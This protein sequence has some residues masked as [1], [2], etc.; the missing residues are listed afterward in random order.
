MERRRFLQVTGGGAL[1]LLGGAG[2]L[3]TRETRGVP[4]PAEPLRFFTPRE[5]AIFTAVAETV[6]QPPA[7]QPTVKEIGVALRADA[8]LASKDA[9]SRKDVRRLLALFDNALAGFMLNGSVAPFSQL[10]LVGREEFLRTWQDHR[11]PVLRAGFSVLKRL[12]AT[13]YYS[14]PSTHR[15]IGYPGPPELLP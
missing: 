15:G 7:G 4:L 10:D 5:Y 14:H 2:L 3:F 9:D 6:V 13:C 12:A 11:L 1:A 8:L